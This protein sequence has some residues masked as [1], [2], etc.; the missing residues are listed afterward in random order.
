[1]RAR[2]ALAASA[3]VTLALGAAAAPAGAA[4][5]TISLEGWDD[6]A[7]AFSGRWLVVGEA[8]TVRVDPRRIPGSPPGAR[9]FD[10]YRA[11]TARVRLNRPRTRFSGGPEVTV[12]V[13]TS[14][15][16]L[17]AGVLGPGGAGTFVTVPSSRRAA[18]PVV[19]CCDAEGIETVVESD[20]RADA[21]LPLAAA[22]DAGRVR[23]VLAGVAGTTL[24]GVD[25]VGL[26]E[27]RTAVAVPV[28]TGPGLVAM[29]GALLAWVDP[30]EPAVL[31][32]AAVTDG[33]LGPVLAAPLPAP[34]LRVWTDRA[35]TVVAVR[36]GR[37]VR[38]LR[39]GAG[40]GAAR[41]IWSGSR[42]PR[43]GV[44]GGSVA[45]ADGRRVLA[46]RTGP[47]RL[48]RRARGRVPAVAVDGSRLAW[49]ERVVVRRARTTVA[50]LGAL[51]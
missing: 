49:L 3:L 19:W 12:S 25:P 4:S 9:P 40:S 23:Y 27:R 43:V 1:M 37:R 6:Q 33:G 35:V 48:Q 34:A 26:G 17:G 38:L 45:V 42:L 31:R 15:A 13:R 8:A 36:A 51:R 39:L 22:P 18:T 44:G 7:L 30:A 14:I 5:R 47:V 28:R 11:E 50:R 46:A 16:A 29:A 24:V 32:R 21:P 2:G 10:Y 41:A 20:G